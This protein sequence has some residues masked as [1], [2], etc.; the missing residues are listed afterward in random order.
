M[1]EAWREAPKK[2]YEAPVDLLF[3]NWQKYIDQHQASEAVPS[4]MAKNWQW[5][6]QVGKKY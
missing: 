4:I 1:G 5:D 3:E 6:S 2:S